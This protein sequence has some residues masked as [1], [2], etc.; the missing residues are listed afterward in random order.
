MMSKRDSILAAIDEHLDTERFKLQHW[1]GAFFDY[2]DLVIA[3]PRL[4]RNAF[5][6]IYDMILHFGTTRYTAHKQ[7]VVHYKFFDDPFEY[8]ADAVFGLDGALCC[9]TAR[10]A[11]ARARSHGC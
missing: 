11:R 1:E 10:S 5:Q 8:G 6:R 7:E 3:N 9:C 2:L 4:L